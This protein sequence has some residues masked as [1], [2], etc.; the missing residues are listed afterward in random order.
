MTMK[1]IIISTSLIVFALLSSC[2]KT[3]TCECKGIQTITYIDDS[4][5]TPIKPTAY[6]NIYDSSTQK[7]K[8]S[9][10]E[11]NCSGRGASI[12]SSR[13]YNWGESGNSTA[14]VNCV[15]K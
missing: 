10:A 8:K 1:N 4:D 9:S 13:T 12:T 5:G 11:G 3:Y 2:S 15:L 6:I 14:V 7:N